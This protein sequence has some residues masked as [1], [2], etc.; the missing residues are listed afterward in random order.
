MR[1]IAQEEAERHMVDCPEAANLRHWSKTYSATPH[2]AGDLQHAEA[3]RD[4]WRSYGI[5]TDL[6]QYDVL[7]NFPI[8]TAL[9][10]HSDGGAIAYEASLTEAKLDEDSTS[11]PENG[12][13]AFHGFSADGEVHA[14][15][16]YANFGTLADFQRLEA[17]GVSVRGRI[18][19]C[20]Y[21]KVF[22]GLKVR[23]AEQF[24]AA[25]V[26]IY[27][28]PQEDGALTAA[29]GHA[30]YPD[31]P[32]RHPTSV[33]RGSV[34]AFSVAVGDP[35][36]P[37][38]PSL[39]GGDTE[40]RDPRQDPRRAIPGIPSLPISYADATPFLEALNGRGLSPEEVGGSQGDWR[41]ALS[42]IEYR[43]GPSVSKVTLLNRGEYRYSPIYNVIGTI[44]G[45]VDEVVML[46][47]HHDSWCCGAVDP[48]SGSAA[49]NEVARGL[50]ELQKAGWKPY[51]KV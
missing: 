13:P 15:L 24:G 34:D 46:G 5:T 6:V 11:S 43:T 36:T 30:A 12:Y 9:T 1:T 50:G 49:I 47:S 39:P 37:G 26:V 33:Q 16:V 23:A 14:E 41:G 28:D 7:Q 51:R 27:S 17:A 25:G 8:K 32:A 3:I 4:L 44:P 42:G 2:L 21:G 40:R 29:N 22:R 10:L 31:G 45:R 38:Y 19:L 35:S 20:K 18:A 48:V